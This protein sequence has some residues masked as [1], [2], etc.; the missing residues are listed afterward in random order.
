MR[1]TVAGLAAAALAAGCT[2]GDPG[3]ASRVAALEAKAGAL[4]VQVEKLSAELAA[5]KA[6]RGAPSGDRAEAAD[7]KAEVEALRVEL[8]SLKSKGLHV[9][10]PN[11]V[12][13]PPA[14][15][16]PEQ[17]EGGPPKTEGAKR[18]KGADAGGAGV[19]S[20]P[21]G[22]ALGRAGVKSAPPGSALG[23]AGVKSAPPGSALE[24]AGEGKRP[25]DGAHG[26]RGGADK[27]RKAKPP[28]TDAPAEGGVQHVPRFP[29]AQVTFG[30]TDLANVR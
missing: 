22:S 4:S 1:W 28:G 26:G 2:G 17:G 15:S 25:K 18:R 7:L 11:A 6:A 29:P 10:K 13:L 14:G 21:P 30:Q 8:E 24:R 9:E 12:L 3:L 19:K 23:R 20:A 27:P 16:G 5:A